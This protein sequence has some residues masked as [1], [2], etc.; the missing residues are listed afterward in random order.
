M[1]S[2]RT[3][4]WVGAATSVVVAAGAGAVVWTHP[5]L[6]RSSPAAPPP[7]VASAPQPKPAS[8]PKVPPVVQAAAPAATSPPAPGK[9]PSQAAALPLEPAFDVVNVDPSGDAVIAGRAA[10]NAK[11]ELRDAGKTVAEAT[12]DA[13]GQFV[14]IPSAPLAPGDH[15]LSLAAN[16]EKAGPE[17]SKTVAVSVAAPN[18]KVA[19]LNPPPDAKA[20]ASSPTQEAKAAALTPA[21]APAPTLATRNLAKPPSPAGSR[22]AIQT[23]EADAA[24][25]L[26]ARGFAEPNATVRLY[27]ND[28]D[29]ADAKTKADGRWSLTIK[30]G[31]IPGGY[32]MRADEISPGRAAVIASANTPF[33]Y[34]EAA[35]SASPAAI[36]AGSS[37]AEPSSSPSPADPVIDS[38]QTKRVATGHTL[39]ELSRNYYGDPTRYPEIYEANKWEIHNPNLIFPGQVVVVPKSGPKP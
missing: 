39:W 21:N 23:V 5:G 9:A 15:S 25:G 4:I 7:V 11:V 16:D 22:V 34:P 38:V 20:G 8:T 3:V 24:G 31:M 6:L 14:I 28:A 32:L 13:A 37:S 10:P 1:L 36:I 2:Q 30:N 27:L 17:T 18:A 35:P 26:I 29:V 19:V 12:A 33:D